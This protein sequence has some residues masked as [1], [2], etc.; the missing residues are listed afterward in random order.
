MAPVAAFEQ[1]VIVELRRADP[2]RCIV[3]WPPRSA[4]FSVAAPDD[5]IAVS[6]HGWDIPNFNS[7]F[8]AFAKALISAAS[9]YLVVATDP[10]QFKDAYQIT[11]SLCLDALP[12]DDKPNGKSKYHH[13]GHHSHAGLN[14]SSRETISAAGHA[15]AHDLVALV[16]QQPR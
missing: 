3:L 1:Q 4:A 6:M 7:E 13:N 12:T 2:V 15:L 9:V 5:P 16:A 8:H 11:L 14:K 10:L